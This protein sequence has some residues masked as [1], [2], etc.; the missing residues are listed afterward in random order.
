MK[1]TLS[2]LSL[3]RMRKYLV[4]VSCPTGLW[5]FSSDGSGIVYLVNEFGFT[6]LGKE[7]NEAGVHIITACCSGC[8]QATTCQAHGRTVTSMPELSPPKGRGMCA[9]T[10]PRQMEL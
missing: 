3:S 10:L 9:S 1:Q 6:L 7:E 8:R 2:S 5:T 4:K